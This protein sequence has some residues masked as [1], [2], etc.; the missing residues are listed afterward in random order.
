MIDYTQKDFTTDHEL[1]DIIFDTVGKSSFAQSKQAL[2]PGGIYLTTVLS[3]GALT[4]TLTTSMLGDKRAI[5][6]AGACAPAK[7]NVAI[8]SLSKR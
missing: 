4:S 1:Y 3:L 5:F 7:K 6:A 8:C 2:K